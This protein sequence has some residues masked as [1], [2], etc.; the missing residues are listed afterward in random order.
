M[1]IISKDLKKIKLAES[2]IMTEI[3]YPVAPHLQ[4]GYKNILAGVYPISEKIHSETLSLP[5]SICH[6]EVEIRY[7]SR[8]LKELLS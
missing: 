5:I 8:K 4:E 6:S 2:G 1:I 3:H 7:V